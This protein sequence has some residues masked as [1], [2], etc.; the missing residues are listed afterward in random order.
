MRPRRLGQ[1]AV[2]VVGAKNE[3]EFDLTCALNSGEA[4]T[5]STAVPGPCQFSFL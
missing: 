4:P 2:D 3:V 1:A 5:V